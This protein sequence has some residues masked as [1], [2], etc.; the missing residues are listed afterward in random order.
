MLFSRNK[1]AQLS[2]TEAAAGEREGDLVLVDVREGDERLQSRPAGSR[3]I[4][5]GELPNRIGELPRD[6]TVAFICRSGSRS[7]MATR[8][9]ADRGLKVA[10]VRG[11]L[12]A[13]NEAGL[14]TESG[15]ER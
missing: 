13:W 8:A 3:H 9:G 12:I 14:P 11:G 6:R 1:T 4:P 5:L 7:A 2:P 15:A 10:N